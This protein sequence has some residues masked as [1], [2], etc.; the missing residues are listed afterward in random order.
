[1]LL[2]SVGHPKTQNT[3]AQLLSTFTSWVFHRALI[4]ILRCYIL[5]QNRVA[6]TAHL[7]FRLFSC[8]LKMS[9][10]VPA[11][12]FVL[13]KTFFRFCSNIFSARELSNQIQSLLTFRFETRQKRRN[14]MLVRTVVPNIT[15]DI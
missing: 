10:F 7:H 8:G 5:T 14:K 9:R 2:G 4:H 3:F 6:S 1:M 12:A 15:I 11:L 13:K